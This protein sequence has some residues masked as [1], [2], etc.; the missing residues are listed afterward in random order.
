MLVEFL[1]RLAVSPAAAAPG[2]RWQ[3]RAGAGAGWR[4]G[5]GSQGTV[6]PSGQPSLPTALLAC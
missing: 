3:G 2:W 1:R 6:R 5:L 4:P